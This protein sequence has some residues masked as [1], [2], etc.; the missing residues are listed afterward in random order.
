MYRYLLIDHM[1]NDVYNLEELPP[2][3]A[4]FWGSDD[5]T[6]H[7]MASLV[8]IAED[9][10]CEKANVDYA[11]DGTTIITWELCENRSRRDLADMYEPWDGSVIELKCDRCG[12]RFDGT[13]EQIND[14]CLECKEG[15][16]RKFTDDVPQFKCTQDQGDGQVYTCVDH[17][18]PIHGGR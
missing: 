11:D 12:Y 13:A 16:V 10:V 17:N 14:I 18:C 5:E 3:N 9:R 1:N 2:A 6:F 8:R 4:W 7:G 15:Y